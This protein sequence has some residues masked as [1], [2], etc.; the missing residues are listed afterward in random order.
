MSIFNK[1]LTVDFCSAEAPPEI[2]VVQGEAKARI[3]HLKLSD[4]DTAVNLTGCTARIF[5]LPHGEATPLYEDLTITSASTG[6][7]DY[8]VS[9]NSA[10]V[11][12]SGLYWIEVLQAGSPDPVLVGYSRTGRFTVQEKPDFTGAIEASTAFSA[13]LSA[14]ATAVG[15]DALAVH[16]AGAETITG[17][18]TFS[19]SVTVPA[20]TTDMQA[21]TK[22][23]VDD[24][25]AN[26]GTRYVAIQT[27][28]KNFSGAEILVM[29]QTV[30]AGTYIIEALFA[31]PGV[32][33]CSNFRLSTGG[34]LS[35]AGLI[36]RVEVFATSTT[37]NAYATAASGTSY[38]DGDRGYIHACRIK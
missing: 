29:T 32:S 30:P 31:H 20:P 13:L 7:C 22:K 25:V 1:T 12:G 38:V 27:E 16:K 24:K 18:K 33:G 35:G 5:I 15:L 19:G 14:L 4:G 37:I 11:A 26:T 36:G 21:S 8:L 23:Y 10:A 28:T 3:V 6:K 2:R 34:I 9:G 17:A